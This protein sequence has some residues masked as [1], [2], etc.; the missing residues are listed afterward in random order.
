MGAARPREDCR[1]CALVRR[2]LR[3]RRSVRR[4]A[5]I[6]LLIVFYLGT[7]RLE[8]PKGELPCRARMSE[9]LGDF[10]ACTTC[11]TREEVLPGTSRWTILRLIVVRRAS[12]H[13]SSVVGSGQRP[14]SEGRSSIWAAEAWALELREGSN[15]WRANG[16]LCV[17]WTCVYVFAQT[18]P[19]LAD[20]VG[21]KVWYG[22]APLP[23]FILLWPEMPDYTDYR[24]SWLL[25][26]LDYRS[27]Q[28]NVSRQSRP[29]SL[30]GDA[31]HCAWVG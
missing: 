7:A 23:M 24:V 31:T 15:N 25:Q 5:L 13:T 21:L 2:R 8:V 4:A 19:A 27:R 11:S 22:W 29:Q 20:D 18:W 14:G 28:G 1:D 9:L 12:G 16:P 3:A 17:L 10:L 30:H 26:C 6:V